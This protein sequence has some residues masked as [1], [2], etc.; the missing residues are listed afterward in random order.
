MPRRSK[1]TFS[2]N[3]DTVSIM[4]EGWNEVALATYRA[5]YYDELLRGG[6]RI[7]RRSGS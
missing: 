6:S 5:D 4:R 1:N 7:E 3:G 2:I